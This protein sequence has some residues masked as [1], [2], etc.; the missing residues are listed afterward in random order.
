MSQRTKKGAKPGCGRC[1]R[2]GGYFWLH[3]LT[4]HEIWRDQ[5]VLHDEW[6]LQAL[7]RESEDRHLTLRVLLRDRY[8]EMP[9]KTR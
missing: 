8:P 5:Y 9:P 3:E 1:S 2:C 4:K 6:C 7:R